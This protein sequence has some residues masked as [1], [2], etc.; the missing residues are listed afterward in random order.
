MYVYLDIRQ[1]KKGRLWD[2][3]W[4]WQNLA[5]QL[6]VN[7]IVFLHISLSFFLFLFSF[8][9]ST[10]AYILLSKNGYTTKK[11]GLTHTDMHSLYSISELRE[12]SRLFFGAIYSIDKEYNSNNNNNNQIIMEADWKEEESAFFHCLSTVI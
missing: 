9:V 3:E 2:G 7:L 5:S 8:F 6:C 11:C 12:R 4:M 10:K 1:Q